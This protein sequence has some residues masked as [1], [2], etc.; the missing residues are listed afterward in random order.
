M[1]GGRIIAALQGLKVISL[2]AR[3]INKYRDIDVT[4][5]IT[6]LSCKTAEKIKGR[7][8]GPFPEVPLY[9]GYVFYSSHGAMRTS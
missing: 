5:G 1:R 6:M 7:N 3:F 2:R 9:P 8:L 4:F